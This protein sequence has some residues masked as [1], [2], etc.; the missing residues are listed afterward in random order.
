[1]PLRWEVASGVGY[2]AIGGAVGAFLNPVID[3][4]GNIPAPLEA[5]L[6]TMAGGLIAG[7]LGANAQG[8]ANAAE[9]ETLNN[10]LNHVRSNPMV[11]SEQER[12]DVLG[13]ACGKGDAASCASYKALQAL[14]AQRDADL[15]SACSAGFSSPGCRS[16][17]TAALASG[18]DV[19]A[20]NGTVYAFDPNTPAIK[21]IGDPYQNV[22]AN[23]FDGQV[24]QSTA[25]ALQFA[26]F[27]WPVAGL[28]GKIGSWIGFGTG[29]AGR[30]SMPVTLMLDASAGAKNDVVLGADS[31][32]NIANAQRLAQQLRLESANSPFAAN[33]MLTQD[34]IGDATQIIA[35][36]DLSNS[37]IPGG[38]GKYTTSTYQS[39]AGNFQV[40]FYKNPATGQ[41]YYGLDY[42]AIF[43]GGI[44][45][46]P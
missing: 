6:T 17:V 12:S 21:A 37:A 24:A 38:F 32:Q 28:I 9:N 40:H 22:Y 29:D 7:A 20:V 35:P 19:R 15:A 43:N 16:Q 39:P 5:A 42:K 41:V 26:P 2:G 14:S 34:A 23:S 31:A 44:P 30:L 45:K 25:D 27:E 10:W 8:A 1:M 36:G 33:G 11:L 46:A 18:N 4:T 3:P 13:T